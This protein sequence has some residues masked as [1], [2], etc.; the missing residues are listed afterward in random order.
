MQHSP[1]LHYMKKKEIYKLSFYKI[2][3]NQLKMHLQ[4]MSFWKLPGGA[5]WVREIKTNGQKLLQVHS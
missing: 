1:N 3:C 5:F 2:Q 4:E